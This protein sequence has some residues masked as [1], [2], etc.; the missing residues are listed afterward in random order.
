MR[1][2]HVAAGHL[3]EQDVAR[4][5]NRLG[6]AGNAFQAELR[7]LR[8]LVRAAV[9]LE[10]RIF[11]VLDHRHVEHARVF[12]RATREERRGHRMP[13]V[14]HRDTAGLAKLRNVGQLLALLPARDRADRIDP[15]QPGLGRLLE[16]EARDA[17]VVVH[18][19][20]VGH[21]RD[22]GEPARDRR[23]DTR[24]HRFLVLLPRLAQ[25]HVHVDEARAD[26]EPGRQCHDLTTVGEAHRQV[27][28]DPRD[29]I[30]ID[31]HVERTV[32][33]V[34]RIDDPASLKQPFHVPLRRPAGRAPPCGRPPHLPPGRES[35]RRDRLRPRR[36]SPRRG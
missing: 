23:V 13:I 18:R 28:L 29:P 17:G 19:I 20:R 11:A 26:D 9:A 14:G 31:E 3:G 16:D 25:V 32:E 30:A 21:A 36:Q 15:R 1:D 10:G 6:H 22:G 34:G 35:L 12:E 27:G 8:A 5:R 33:T 2:V 7:R 24:G 4:G